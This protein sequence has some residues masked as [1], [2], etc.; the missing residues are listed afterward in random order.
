MKQFESVIVVGASAAGISCVRTLRQQGFSGS[1]TLVDKD[2]H[3]AYERPPLSKQILMQADSTH[4]D[5]ALISDDELTALNIEAHYGDGVRQLDPTTRTIILESGKALTADAIVLA[6]GGEAR[7]LPIEGSNLPQVLVLRHY[8]DALNLRQRLTADTRVAVIGGGFIGAETTASLSKSSAS[9]QWLDAAALPM[10]HLLP[11]ELCEKIVANHCA[12]GVTLTSHC[13]LDKFIEQADGSVAILFDDGTSIEVDVIV[14]GVGMAPSTPY[15]SDAISAE[16]LNPATGG[17]QVNDNQA[18]K[19]AGVYAAGDVAAV[20]QADGSTVRHE[21]WQSAQHQ[22]ERAA[23]AI[24]NQELPVA[25]VDWFWSDQGDLHIE[26]AGKILPTKEHLVMRLEGE[27]P[28]YFSVVDNRVVGAV[29]VN[30]PNAVRAA[31]RMIKNDVNVE[32]SQLANPEL[33]LRKLMRG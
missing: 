33:P 7:R 18:T 15:L 24:L 17:I 12:Q 30:N 10:A 11:A 28:V 16:L 20:T 21:H 5:I 25:P 27:W 32:P 23:A 3:S 8:E 4:H 29:S 13:R 14:M 26:M 1:I 6:T 31:M 9:I 22:G 2:Q 19:F